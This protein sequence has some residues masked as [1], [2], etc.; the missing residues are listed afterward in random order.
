MRTAANPGGLT[1]FL[2]LEPMDC[3]RQCGSCQVHTL[4]PKPISNQTRG[5]SF[6][7]VARSREEALSGDHIPLD[8]YAA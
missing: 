4:P 8:L 3:W 7:F 2:P 6:F 5:L 1:R